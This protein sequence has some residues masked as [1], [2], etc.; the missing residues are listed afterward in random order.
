M[1]LPKPKSCKNIEEIR[2]ALDAIDQDLIQLFSLRNQYVREIVKFKKGN[3]EGIIASERRD[4][5]I[6]QRRAWAQSKGLD[7]DLMEKVFSLL[8]EKNIQIQFDMINSDN[9]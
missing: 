4:L 9:T 1:T 7:P 3:K 8:I 2:N 6:K 5:V